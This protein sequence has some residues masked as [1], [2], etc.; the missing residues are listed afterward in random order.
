M[1]ATRQIGLAVTLAALIA[2][3]PGDAEPVA[4]QAAGYVDVR[5]GELVTPALIVVDGERI[6]AVKNASAPDGA[7]IIDLH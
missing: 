3:H 6:A 7:K 5:A 1:R 2:P 4:I